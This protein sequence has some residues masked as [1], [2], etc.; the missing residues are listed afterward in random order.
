[1]KTFNVSQIVIYIIQALCLPA[2]PRGHICVAIRAACLDH[3]IEYLGY[4]KQY[5]ETQ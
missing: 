3:T 5:I 4:I 2:C 1:M